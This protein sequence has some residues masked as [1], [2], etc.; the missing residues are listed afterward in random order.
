MKKISIIL[1]MG[2]LMT[3]SSLYSQTVQKW[4][5]DFDGTVTFTATPAS[6]WV[7]D[8][9][10]YL[11]GSSA[12]NP[13][14]YLGL[15]PTDTGKISIL[16]TDIY[17]CTSSQYVMLK[18]SHICKV[19]PQDNVRIEYRKNTGA[20]MGKWEVIPYGAYLGSATNYRTTGFNA[21]SYTEWMEKDNAVF[22]AQ[23]WW[24]EESFDISVEAGYSSVQFRFVIEHGSQQGT[25]LSYGWLLDNVEILAASHELFLPKVAFRGSYPKDTVYSIGP[26]VIDALVKSSTAARIRNPWLVYTSTYNG[27]SLTD[28]VEMQHVAGDSLWRETLPVFCAG[29]SV[30]YSITGKDILGNYATIQAIYYV[31]KSQTG[32]FTRY[33][34]YSPADTIGTIHNYGIIFY[35]RSSNSWSRSLFI[36]SE[37]VGNIMSNQP[38]VISKI[39]WYNRSYNYTH[40][41]TNLKIYLEETNLTTNTNTVYI[42]PVAN[43]ATLVYSGG[44]TTQLYWNE[45]LLDRPFILPPGKNLMIYFEENSGSAGTAGNILWAASSTTGRTVFDYGTG[46][47]N[48]A[49]CCPLMRFALGSTAHGPHSASIVSIN[50]PI[51]GQTSGGISTPIAISLQNKGDSTLENINI[52][53]TVNGGVVNTY[54]WTGNLLWDYTEDIHIGNYVPRLEQY[55]T[56]KIWISMPN[57][58]LDTINYDD[59]LSVISF[60]CMPTGMTG[61]YTIGQTGHFKTV[62]EAIDVLKLCMPLGGDITLELESDTYTQGIDLTG[63]DQILGGNTFTITSVTH[64]AKDVIIKPAYGAGIT[65]AR[66]NN[67]IIRDITVDVITTKVNA[68]Q[69]TDNCRNILIRDCK[70]LSDTV[71]PSLYN[72]SNTIIGTDV[73]LDS[74][75]II[76]NLISGGYYGISL[77]NTSSVIQNTNIRVDSNTVQNYYHTGLSLRYSKCISISYNTVLSRIYNSNLTEGNPIYLYVCHSDIVTGNRIKQ[78]GIGITNAYGIRI[79]ENIVSSETMLLSNNEINVSY[80]N[81]GYGLYVDSE[82]ARIFH[83]S[84]YIEGSGNARGISLQGSTNYCNVKNNN[85]IMESSTA[86]PIYINNVNLQQQEFDYNNMWSPKFVGYAGGDHTS[87][88][89]WRQIITTDKYSVSIRPDFVD[90]TVN[91]QL[92]DYTGLECPTNLVFED[93]DYRFRTGETTTMGCYHEI[94]PFTVNATLMDIAGNREGSVKGATDS[95]RVTLINTG[96]TALSKAT[97]KWEWNGSSQPDVIW[98]GALSTGNKITIP[99]GSI[100]YTAA[101][102]YSIKAWIDNL[103]GLTDAYPKDDT[104]SVTGS[105][106]SAP[107]SGKYELGTGVNADFT[108]LAGFINQVS[109][110]GLNGDII[111]E[112]QQGVYTEAMDLSLI[113]KVMEGYSFTLTSTTGNATDVT[114]KTSNVGIILSQ[115]R[116][117]TIKDITVDVTSGTYA[118]Q[119]TGVCTNIVIRD[120]RLLA[121]PT[122]S[123]STTAPI[124]YKASGVNVVDSIFIVN[125][126]LDGGYYGIY[127]YGWGQSAYGKNIVFDSNMVTNQYYYGAYF[128][129]TDFISCSYNTMLSRISNTGIDIGSEWYGIR[130]YY[131]NGD[132]TGNKITQRSSTITTPYGIYSYYHNYYSNISSIKGLIANNEIILNIN[133]TYAGIYAS[134]AKS[135]VINNSIYITGDGAARGIYLANLSYNDMV[136][137]NNNIVLTSPTA[138]PI[139][140]NGTANLN[141]Y[142]I[143]Y[144]N[145][146]APTYVG[147]YGGNITSVADWQQQITTDRHSISIFPNFSSPSTDLKLT[148]YVGVLCNR[149]NSVTVDVNGDT[150]GLITTMGC[151]EGLPSKTVNIMLAEITGTE[152]GYQLAQ[153]DTLEITVY[154]TG[155]TPITSLNLEWSVNG[156]SQNAGGTNYPLMLSGRGQFTTLTL[157]Y[158]TYPAGNIDIKVWLNNVNGGSVVDEYPNDDT[159]SKSLFICTNEYSGILTVGPG[160]GTTFKTIKQATDLLTLCSVNGDISLVFESGVHTGTMNFSDNAS[161]FGDYNIT[162]TSSTDNADD[163]IIRPISGAGV[164]FSNSKNITI[165]ALTIDAATNGTNAVEFIGAADNI[166]IRDCKLLANP[167]TI[168]SKQNPVYKASGTGLANNIFF[169]HNLLDGGYA[170]LYFYAGTG[171]GTGAYGTNIVFDSNT[172]SNSYYAGTYPYYTSFTS[173]SYNTILSRT[174]Y[175]GDTWYGLRMYNANGPVIGNKIIQRSNDVKDPYGILLEYHNHYPTTPTQG[176]ALVAN[177]EIILNATNAYYGIYANYTKSEVVHNSIYIS[178]TGAA[179]GIHIVNS[180]NNS[181]SIKNNNIVLTSPTAYPVYFSA[182]GNLNLYDMDYNNLYAPLFIGYYG[183]NIDSLAE[184][185]NNIPQDLHSVRAIADFI[186]PANSLELSTFNDTLVCPIITAVRG[187]IKGNIRPN[188]TTMGA[189]TKIPVGRDLMLEQITPW[190]AK[191]IYNQNIPINVSLRN[192]ATQDITVATFGWS[193]NGTLQNPVSYTFN[194]PLNSLEQRNISLTTLQITNVDSFNVVLWI[195]TINGQPDT[196]KWND[197]LSALSVRVPLVAFIDPVKDTLN[198]LSFDVIARI[199]TYSG[200]PLTPPILYVETAVKGA[201]FFNDTIAMVLDKD[202]IWVAKIPQQ[203]YDSKVIYSLTVSDA[204]NNTLAIKDSVYIELIKSGIMDHYI[205]YSSKDTMAGVNHTASVF[206]GGRL[207]S[208]SRH[209]FFNGDLE[210]LNPLKET[211]LASVAFRLMSVSVSHRTNIRIYLEATTAT[212]NPASYINPVANGAT[213]VYQGPMTMAFPDWIEIIFSEIFYLPAGHNLMIYLEDYTTTAGTYTWRAVNVN[214]NSICG[215]PI[216]AYDGGTPYYPVTRFGVSGLNPYIGNNLALSEFLSPVNDMDNICAQNYAPVTITMRNLGENDYDF[217]KDSIRI[218][219]EIDDPRGNKYL[220]YITIDTGKFKSGREDMIDLIT[221]FPIMYAG[222]YEMKAWVESSIDYVRYDDT[223]FYTYSSGRIGLP[224]DND[225]SNSTLSSDFISVPI[226][227]LDM[228]TPYSNS[229]DPVQPVFGSGMLKYGGEQ[230]SMA[231]IS[232]RQLDLNGAINPKLEF[233]YYH[234]AAASALDR[235]YTDVNVI[236]DGV[237]V[238]VLTVFRKDAT[239][240]WKQYTVDLDPYTSAQCVLIE[241]KSMNKFGTQSIQ[242]IDRIFITSKQDLAVQEIILSPEVNVCSLENKTLSVVLTATTNQAIDFSQYTDS[243]LVEVPGYSIFKIPLTHEIAGKTADTVLINS[244]INIATGTNNIKAYLHSPVDNIPL[245]DTATLPIDIRPELSITVNSLTNGINCFRIGEEVR[246]EV[247]IRNTGNVDIPEIALTTYVD[248]STPQTVNDLLSTPLKAGDSVLHVFANPY[249]TPSDAIYQVIVTAWMKCDSIRANNRNATNECA[250][251]HDISIIRMDNPSDQTDIAGSTENIEIAIE[252][253]SD[254]QIFSNITVIAMI[255]DENGTML[256]SRIGIIPNAEPLKTTSFAFTE[257]YSVP[258]D[259]VYYIRVYLNKVDNYPENDTLITKR[260]TESVG[261]KATRGIDIFTLGQNIPNP[262]TNSTRINYNVPEAGEVVFHVHSISGQLLHSQN[263]EA[264]HGT[265]SIELNTS[266]FAA[267][268]YFYSMEYKGRRLIRQLIINN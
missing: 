126:L 14:S 85:V 87:L 143:D 83:N 21:A 35:V 265:N 81:S 177:N 259:S 212:T 179:K 7:L 254:V 4:T 90:S 176:K 263:I 192:T 33:V 232:T 268:V 180:T 135:E 68:I 119:F 198:V 79:F 39:A 61:T 239:Q 161:L 95:I 122:N 267:G 31:K 137:K 139:Y 27:V 193:L 233:W 65:L 54:P 34:Y 101:G 132:I 245:N 204:I 249:I 129:Y 48:T 173:C 49:N 17:D 60:G 76:H 258:Y 36:N 47:A 64:D 52:H 12:N 184:W 106:C 116:N 237:S 97:V 38:T 55:D 134:Y 154:N 149:I 225:F 72:T 160:A 189:Y 253:T 163:A 74:I 262:A 209:L 255:E 190:N 107:L 46:V 194:P 166:L 103:D 130:G 213:L 13:K 216:G 59:T 172:V 252:N 118:I 77:N 235:S 199:P 23:S 151:Y 202:D 266:T 37:L 241:F 146:Y 71:T 165:K 100:T 131:V 208:W 66:S 195:N 238:T 1:V 50:S 108:S 62:E 45:V 203:Y 32:G 196:V 153:T 227:D 29:T 69:F 231:H 98:R 221:S 152:E 229:G 175:T 112:L 224:M 244:N 200:A 158:L 264:S 164:I 6:S 105:V 113:A 148:N 128:Y 121:N 3:I 205:Y 15:V 210:N 223:I 24:K 157:G 256:S 140:M 2:I 246:Q 174:A 41:R 28:S 91:L 218:H 147:Y 215:D 120:C 30:T 228:W 250:D 136:I 167:T 70:L 8:T 156:V 207:N 234:D 5:E 242:Y 217:T 251:I 22:P 186:N 43:G 169:I 150:R 133:N 171:T 226:I 10:F 181:M 111:M 201:Y 214:A 230:G 240:G 211:P 11:P 9:T 219:F 123:S 144:N 56:V 40:V 168:S 261:I 73:V 145:L 155:T 191:V 159:V 110:C 53:W 80:N 220:E 78:R 20:L 117:I 178:G 67:I 94:A 187:D 89:S 243:L 88:N 206:Y 25:Q 96:A 182:K 236:V 138:H 51:Q 260:Y 222:K 114:I 93:I 82:N 92:L 44:T 141:L 57:G 125:N 19:S 42:D 18:F 84:I 248:A 124:Y 102:N 185:Q 247:M 26:Y 75:F 99:L 162:L 188:I 127:F 197:T 86:Y 104:V 170:G 63:I 115:N 183:A 109:F 142:D 58:Y 257:D 16:E